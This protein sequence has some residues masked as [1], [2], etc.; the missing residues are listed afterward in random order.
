VALLIWL[1]RPSPPQPGGVAGEDTRYA[2][3]A[4]PE[5]THARMAS[6]C[7]G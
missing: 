6:L 7:S 5:A 4:A 1:E 3:P 2:L